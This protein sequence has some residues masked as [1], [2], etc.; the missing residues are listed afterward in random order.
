MSAKIEQQYR[1]LLRQASQQPV[2]EDRTG[3]G[4]RSIF[5]PTPLQHNLNN[6]FPLFLGKRIYWRGVV[7][8]LLWFLRGDTN[9]RWLQD[10]KVHIWDEWA[11]ENGDLGPVYGAQ[12]AR[13]LPQVI[14]Q[15]KTNPRS[16]RLIVNCWQLDDLPK[17]ALP[18]C[19]TMFQF[20]VSHDNLL[21]C[22]VYQRSGDLFLGVPFNVASYALLTDIIAQECGLSVGTLTLVLGDAHVY[23][24]HG[25]QVAEYLSRDLPLNLPE[26]RLDPNVGWRDHT[27]DTIR[28]EGYH[29]L[30]AIKAPVAV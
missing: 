17:M 19:H 13:Q 26:V 5:A 21:S 20:H 4:T 22:Q 3:V 6:G 27:F 25:E 10:N 15:I 7:G 18:P 24:N 1:D 23:A 14:E 16:R 11:D 30:P 29:P 12:W 9:V 8:E 2:V 28:L